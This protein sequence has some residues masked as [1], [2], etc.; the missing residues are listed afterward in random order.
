MLAPLGRPR[1]R[2]LRVLGSAG[3]ATDRVQF[4][5]HQPREKY[6]ATYHRI[7]IGID[8][9]PYNGH[10]TSLDSFWMGVPV[11][12]RIGQRAVGRAGFS[13]LSN[14]GLTELAATDDESF[15]RIATDLAHDL[16]RLM[17]LRSSLRD[18][19]R[20][21]PLGDPKRFARAVEAAYRRMWRRWCAGTIRA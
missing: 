20:E 7:D 6:L 21:S 1:E 15:V 3:V 19:M 8:T 14:L 18:R 17:E 4:V 13:Q 9:F 5:S 16:P 12:T 2:V 11:V 10:M